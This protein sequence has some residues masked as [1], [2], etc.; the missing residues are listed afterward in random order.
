MQTD[1]R[2]FLVVSLILLP[3]AFLFC[4]STLGLLFGSNSLSDADLN[5][6]H[7]TGSI[8]L[9]GIL[10]ITASL[11]FLIVARE[12][13]EETATEGFSRHMLSWVFRL[14]ALF[15]GGLCAF[16]GL[17]LFLSSIR[18]GYAN[19]KEWPASTGSILGI[20]SMF[21][22][23]GVLWTITG[24]LLVITYASRTHE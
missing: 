8:A 24:F 13:R 12:K 15:S 19:I 23:V 17:L 1:S 9:G 20:F 7:Y 14:F 4:Y 2:I 21:G 6:V 16:W 10:P 3:L 18:L 11:S 5:F 22:L